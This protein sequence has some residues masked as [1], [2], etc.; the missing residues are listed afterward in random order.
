MR[1]AQR[2]LERILGVRVRIRDHK[3][4]EKI[5]LEYRTLEDF[6]WVIG[7]LKGKG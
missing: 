1:A 3:G 5:T 4:K 2:E 7:M 6:G